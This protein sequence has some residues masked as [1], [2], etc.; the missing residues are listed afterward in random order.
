MYVYEVENKSFNINF[1]SVNYRIHTIILKNKLWL[2][3][4]YIMS[5]NILYKISKEKTWQ[6]QPKKL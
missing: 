4:L 2:T 1:Q 6:R 3:E 5:V